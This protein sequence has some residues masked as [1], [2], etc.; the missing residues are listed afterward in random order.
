M[1]ESLASEPDS[2]RGARSVEA[3]PGRRSRPW[4]AR[5]ATAESSMFLGSCPTRP[6]AASCELRM[7]I[8]VAR[9]EVGRRRGEMKEV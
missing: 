4:R 7:A 5:T 2:A 3:T 9:V 6:P 8:V 1:L